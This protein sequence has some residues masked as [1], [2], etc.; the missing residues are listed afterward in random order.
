MFGE[1]FGCLQNFE[2]HKYISLLFQSLKAFRLF[3]LMRYW[4][5]TKY[6]GS[7]VINK[8]TIAERMEYARWI[9]QQTSKRM[10]K[11]TDRP[12][13]MTY[14]LRHNGEKNLE[15]SKKELDSNANLIITAGSETTATLLS[16]ATYLLLTNPDK[17][18]KLKQE[19]RSKFTTYEEITLAAVN[20]AP[21]L[22]ACLNEALRYF[23]PVPA[24]FERR[25]GK[26]GEVVS[27]HYMPEGTAVS[28][29]QY[30]ANHSEAHFK[31][32]NRF[33]PERWMGEEE[34]A[35]DKRSVVQPFSYGPRACLGKVSRKE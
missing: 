4:P 21:Y 29:S 34:F 33:I 11:E 35:N 15:L 3:Y 31:Y 9:A 13:F 28:V 16:G 17:H 1:P 8:K 5:I 22:I 12:D 6:L 26:G 27:G 23:P 2:T 10:A 18:D 19:L 30:P 14:I 25:I 20:N 32:P 24:G 7:L